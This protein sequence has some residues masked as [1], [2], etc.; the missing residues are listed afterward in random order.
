MASCFLWRKEYSGERPE[1]FTDMQSLKRRN[2]RVRNAVMVSFVLFLFLLLACSVAFVLTFN[3]LD[4]DDIA[5]F[6]L[7]IT[8]SLIFTVYLGWVI[9]KINKNVNR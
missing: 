9:R 4:I 1:S 5:Q 7:G 6:I 3:L 8:L 2:E